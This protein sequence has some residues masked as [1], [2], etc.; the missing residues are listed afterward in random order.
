[1]VDFYIL[2]YNMTRQVFSVFTSRILATDLWQS[3]CN[4]STHKVF[5]SQADFQV[6]AGLVAISS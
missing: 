1:M 4:Y 3:H 6:S 5:S 2:Q